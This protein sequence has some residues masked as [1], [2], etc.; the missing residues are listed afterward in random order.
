MSEPSKKGF[1]LLTEVDSYGDGLL[2]QI[3]SPVKDSIKNYGNLIGNVGKLIGNDIGTLLKQTFGRLGKQR[4]IMKNWQSNRKKHLGNVSKNVDDLLGSSPDGHLMALMLSPGA[5]FTRMGV[6]GAKDVASPEFRSAMGEFGLDGIPIFGRIFKKVDSTGSSQFWSSIQRDI[7]DE[8]WKGAGET[9][10]RQIKSWMGEAGVGKKDDSSLFQAINSIFLWAHHS[11]DGDVLKEAEEKS[12][13][14][15]DVKKE[16]NKFLQK[17]LESE[18]P[19]DR[20]AVLEEVEKSINKIADSAEKIISLNSELAACETSDT[21]LST[22]KGLNSLIEEKSQIN[23]DDVKK[24]IDDVRSKIEN[25]DEVL[26]TIKKE[27]E[28]S[29]EE[30]SDK[31][32]KAKIEEIVMNQFKSTY[33]P[34]LKDYLLDYYDDVSNLIQGGVDDESYKALEQSKHGKKYISLVNAQQKKIDAALTKMKKS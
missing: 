20:N 5:Y 26:D 24:S 6:Q 17:E 21:F 34:T 30:V 1:T 15:E 31:I 3:I 22:L 7:D 27:I 12:V 11:P 2:T 33:L 32:G 16:F 25:N 9:L 8:D 13:S 29:G 10:E 23:I 19:I 28:D 18:W 4:E 14:E